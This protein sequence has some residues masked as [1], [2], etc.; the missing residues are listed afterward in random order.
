MPV[1][2]SIPTPLR[3]LT[4][5]QKILEVEDSEDI[6]VLHKDEGRYEID[7]N[8]PVKNGDQLSIVPPIAGG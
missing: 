4:N 1:F 5:G 2:I 3:A 7:V 6:R 8:N